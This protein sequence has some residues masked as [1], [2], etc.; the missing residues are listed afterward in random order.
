M[1]QPSLSTRDL[2]IRFGGHV[3]VNQ[4]TADFYPGTL[5]VIDARTRAKMRDV[6]VSGE[7]AAGQVT[8]LFGPNGR[9]YAAETG[10]DAVAE[11][12][13]ESG[14]VLRRLKALVGSL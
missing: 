5:T 4:V 13:L 2:T 8:I 1:S 9:L 11:I 14:R 10:R 12:D 7:G 6:S 3:A